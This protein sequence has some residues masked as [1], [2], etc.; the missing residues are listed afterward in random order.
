MTLRFTSLR[1]SAP[2]RGSALF[3]VL[4]AVSLAAFLLLVGLGPDA[5][6]FQPGA[7]YSDAA[8]S[9]WPNA[10]FLRHSVLDD[11]ALPLWRPL[12]MSGQPFAANPLNK[13]WY[14]PQW[15]VLLIAPAL[16]LT[17]LTWLHLL[18]AGVGCMGLG[19]RDRLTS[20]ARRAGRIW[21]R[22]RAAPDRDRSEPG[23]WTSSTRRDGYPG[24][25][26]LFSA[27]RSR[28]PR[29]APGSR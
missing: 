25:C 24:C 21:L 26:G 2:D 19:P 14:P 4:L 9:H 11:H 7:P 27:P 17:I 28:I 22:V 20:L 1:P 18:I 16:H 6:P 3:V 29:A 13:V 23:T 5:L 10:L 8:I 12:L 15:L